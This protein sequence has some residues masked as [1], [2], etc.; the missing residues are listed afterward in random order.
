[1]LLDLLWPSNYWGENMSD[2]L[3]IRRDSKKRTIK[4][5]INNPQSPEEEKEVEE[6]VKLVK[7]ASESL[8]K[9]VEDIGNV[10]RAIATS[11]SPWIDSIL[12][13]KKEILEFARVTMISLEKLRTVQEPIYRSHK[14]D[15]IT[16]PP[17]FNEFSLPDFYGMFKDRSS[18]VEVYDEYFSKSE[19]TKKLLEQWKEEECY[20]GRLEILEDALDAHVNGKHTISIPTL[21]A[22]IEGVLGAILATNKHGSIKSHLKK[23][24]MIGKD[25]ENYLPGPEIIAN[26]I[27]KEIFKNAS[28]DLDQDFPLRHRILHGHSVDYYKNK[29]ASIRCILILDFLRMDEFKVKKY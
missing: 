12:Q 8:I 22:Q 14:N 19:N 17:Y 16:I 3:V 13:H 1:M 10:A 7:V 24:G 29:L 4:E 11:M 23:V 25:D 28:T 20:S 2:T 6:L 18:A 27:H 26:V 15:N 9:P 21:L 5:I